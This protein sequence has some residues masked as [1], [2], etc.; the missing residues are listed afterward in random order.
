MTE[1]RV[2]NAGKFGWKRFREKIVKTE[3]WFR[4]WHAMPRIESR[5][6]SAWDVPSYAFDDITGKSCVRVF[7]T[8]N[9]NYLVKNVMYYVVYPLTSLHR[10][11]AQVSTAWN[12]FSIIEVTTH[13]VQDMAQYFSTDVPTQFS[14]LMTMRTKTESHHVNKLLHSKKRWVG[15]LKWL[16]ES[17]RPVHEAIRFGEAL[18]YRISTWQDMNVHP[19]VCLSVI[20]KNNPPN[21]AEKE[22]F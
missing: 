4:F 20:R 21:I 2:K 6:P 18:A 7:S 11:K 5:F 3:I 9:A 14:Q 16:L 13:S 22:R 8:I 17:T 15:K 12:R 10:T 19:S 1:L